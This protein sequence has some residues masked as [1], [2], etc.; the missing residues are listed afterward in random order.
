MS[1]WMWPPGKAQDSIGSMLRGQPVR[2]T[3]MK[4]DSNHV[5]K[6]LKQ[7]FTFTL[8]TGIVCY[9]KCYPKLSP[10]DFQQQLVISSNT[11]SWWC[12]C[13]HNTALSH[14]NPLAITKVLCHSTGAWLTMSVSK[15]RRDSWTTGDPCVGPT[16]G[17]GYA[18]VQSSGLVTVIHD[19]FLRIVWMHWGP[20]SQEV[21]AGERGNGGNPWRLAPHRVRQD[22]RHVCYS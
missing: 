12:E 17:T 10:K 15:G 22:I 21:E 11:G 1:E 5:L 20:A 4:H 7:H 16:Q 8:S 2:Y 9:G 14:K 6:I 3:R 19:G 18:T 13:W